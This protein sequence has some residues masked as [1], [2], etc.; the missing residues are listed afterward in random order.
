MGGAPGLGARGQHEG[1]RPRD[2]R[3]HRPQHE[4]ALDGRDPGP[5]GRCQGRGAP[6]RPLGSAAAVHHALRRVRGGGP[7]GLQARQVAKR[8]RG[9]PSCCARHHPR[10][11][12]RAC[13][14]TSKAAG[15]LAGA[16]AAARE[17]VGGVREAVGWPSGAA[18]PLHRR[19][20]A[21]L[22]RRLCTRNACGLSGAGPRHRCGSGRRR[23]RGPRSTARRAA[24][25]A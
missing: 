13:P 8:A 24:S 12:R 18:R 6:L 5:P 15:P 23:P 25:P 1:V 22:Q 20:A 17:V 16:A 21:W 7:E 10:P 2:R 3:A 9:G 14:Q 11:C 4:D 19:R